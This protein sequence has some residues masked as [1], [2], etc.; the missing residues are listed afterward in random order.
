MTRR[1]VV[2]VSTEFAP[3][4]AFFLAGQFL[5]FEP[6]VLVL[7]AV[8][9]ACL[10][11]SR[12]YLGQVPVLPLWSGLIVIV[13]G[14][15]TVYF[16]VPDA[17]IFADTM[18][19][20]AFA[21]L[22]AAGFYRSEHFLERVFNATFAVTRE[23]WQK[24][25]WRW[26]WI[27]VAAAIANEYVRIMLTPEFWIDYKFSKVLLITA[28]AAYQVTLA[29]KYRLPEAANTWGFRTATAD[30]TTEQQR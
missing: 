11:I 16:H 28:F 9:V 4:F 6:A 20:L 10:V 15:L 8:T 29:R 2:Q 3:I 5:P 1:A 21:G 7:I 17:I 13:T 19:Y 22:I 30:E 23:G 26:L 27:F 12:W 25:S 18:Y 14:A 24:L